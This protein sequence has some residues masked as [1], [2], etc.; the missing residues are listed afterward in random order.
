MSQRS[1]RTQPGVGRM[2]LWLRQRPARQGLD[3]APPRTSAAPP[4]RDQQ[5]HP[6]ATA[7]QPF[8]APRSRPPGI[9]SSSRM[10]QHHF[11]QRLGDLREK[12]LP[13]GGDA[14]ARG[15]SGTLSRGLPG[16][17]AFQQHSSSSS[18]SSS[19]AEQPL[20]EPLHHLSVQSSYRFPPSL[21][22]S[23]TPPIKWPGNLTAVQLPLSALCQGLGFSSDCTAGQRLPVIPLAPDSDL[24]TLNAHPTVTTFRSHKTS[25]SQKA[26]SVLGF[27]SKRRD[28]HSSRAGFN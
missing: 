1:T 10:A 11:V 12:H 23:Q 6:P 5:L 7:T 16:C 14:T 4:R 25:G 22:H 19:V 18:S 17:A 2:L 13:L 15:A 8:P 26:G 3:S 21:T 27:K 20:S 9:S 24:E 28:K